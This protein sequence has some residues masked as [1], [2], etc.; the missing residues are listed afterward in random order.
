MTQPVFDVD[1]VEEMR[2]WMKM[3]PALAAYGGR[4]R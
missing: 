3:M 2:R 4:R 1:L